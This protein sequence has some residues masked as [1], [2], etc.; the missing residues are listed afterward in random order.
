[1]FNPDQLVETV[2]KAVSNMTMKESPKILQGTQYKSASNYVGRQRQHQLA[3]GANWT[4][5]P[6][7]VCHYCK[8]TGHRKDNCVWL[9]KLVHEIQL[10]EQATAA[11]LATK[12]S[13]GPHVPK[14]RVSSALGPIWRR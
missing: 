5:E 3:C 11:K 14:S 9:S 7:L 8:D 4:L 2:T 12:K 10:Q 6:N 1:M 13:T